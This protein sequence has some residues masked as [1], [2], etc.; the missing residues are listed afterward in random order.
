MAPPLTADYLYRM[1]QAIP[2]D[3]HR[4]VIFPEVY[5]EDHQVNLDIVGAKTHPKFLPPSVYH[6]WPQKG[7]QSHNLG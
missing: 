3:W 2:L 1:E 4:P 6:R 5:Y 7:M